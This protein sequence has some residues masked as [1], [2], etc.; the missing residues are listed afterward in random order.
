MKRFLLAAVAS[1]S[2]VTAAV[3]AQY[4]GDT[5]VPVVPP[6]G[7][8]IVATTNDEPDHTAIY[9]FVNRPFVFDSV[10]A[11]KHVL[12]NMAELRAEFEANEIEAHGPGTTVAWACIP[13]EAPGQDI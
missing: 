10:D 8:H 11:C 7:W 12:D 9:G 3:T 2:L 5:R 1:L 13:V 4:T 6:A